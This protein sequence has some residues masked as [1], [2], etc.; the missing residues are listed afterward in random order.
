MRRRGAC[1]W[2][3]LLPVLFLFWRPSNIGAASVR[4]YTPLEQTLLAAWTAGAERIILPSA[5][6]RADAEQVYFALLDD[7]PGIFW[8]A[9]RFTYVADANGVREILPVYLCSPA[10][11]EGMRERLA[12][13][14]ERLFSVLPRGASDYAVAYALH[15]ALAA[16]TAYG[17]DD[18]APLGTE[19]AYTAYGALIDGTAVCR[20]Y[21][22]AYLLL[23]REAGIDAGYIHSDTM[24]HGWVLAEL[25]GRRLHID[26]TWDDTDTLTHRRFARTDAA[27]AAMGYTDW[28]CG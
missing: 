16:V 17:T 26:V 14:V 20:G 10:E 8:V 19:G 7:V 1:R 5:V 24:A 4:E 9:H 28:R 11:I 27:M 25:D 3:L 13:E 23:L 18:H 2:M 15:D 22:M 21:A 6:P 12:G